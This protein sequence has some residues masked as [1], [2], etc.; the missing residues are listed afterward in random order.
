MGNG[1]VLFKGG[2][3]AKKSLEG[4][5]EEMSLKKIGK[6]NAKVTESQRKKIR[7]V[8][9]F[10][11]MD[12]WD[13]AQNML[14]EVLQENPYY[15]EANWAQ[16][17]INHKAKESD[18]LIGVSFTEYDYEVLTRGL[19]CANETE[20][21]TLLKF[22]YEYGKTVDENGYERLLAFVLPYEYGARAERIKE[23]FSYAIERGY[24]GAFT[25]LISTLDYY[26]IDKYL[27]YQLE[28]ARSTDS[29][30]Y[31]RKCIFDALDIH[32]QSAEAIEE[33][34][35]LQLV[36]EN[37]STVVVT[38]RRILQDSS[39]GNEKIFTFLKRCLIG[40]VK[41][42]YSL[43]VQRMLEYYTGDWQD[44]KADLFNLSCRLIENGDFFYATR[45]LQLMIK[46]ELGDKQIYWKLC[47]AK[48]EVK[49]GVD[50]VNAKILLKSLPE[51]TQY[52]LMEEDEE[53]CLNC[54]ALAKEQAKKS[55]K[56]KRPLSLIKWR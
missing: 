15:F 50:I 49:T 45:I 7:L 16:I 23:A 40:K 14:N 56:E 39:N 18:E 13:D 33:L 37:P 2:G 52:L 8:H 51:Y 3:Y 9:L 53:V 46:N 17:L 31:K 27:Q 19:D 4:K 48:I 5:F 47:L 29:V 35:G 32:P 21:K 34:F 30:E 55:G 43:I 20:A 1:Q 41:G 10:S 44:L 11:K 38:V 12:E 36:S 22:L 54:I 24:Y 25:I 26:E 6:K 28:F 42:E